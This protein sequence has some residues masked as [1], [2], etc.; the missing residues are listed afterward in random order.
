MQDLSITQEYLLCALT[1]KGVIPS[2]SIESP[3]CVVAGGIIELLQSQIVM[4]DEKKKLSVIGDLNQ[5]LIHLKSLYEWIQN[6][7]PMK[8]EKLVG[9]YAMSFSGKKMKKLISDIGNSLDKAD[10]VCTESGGIFGTK[11]CFIPNAK[12]VDKVIQKIR[13]ELLDD[14]EISEETVALVSLLDKSKLLKKYFS[15]YESKQLKNRLQDIKKTSSNLLVKQM[16][17]YV[18]TMVAVIAAISAS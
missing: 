11:S 4:F 9:E 10:C 15:K 7:K 6:E 2:F 14:G 16:V 12:E 13:A 3:V 18:E 1:E 5:E 8:I 17:E